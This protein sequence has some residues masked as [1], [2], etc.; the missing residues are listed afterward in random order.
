MKDQIRVLRV[1][2]YIGQRKWVE[3]TIARS[4]KGTKIVS[5]FGQIRAATIGD[6]P[7][8]LSEAKIMQDESMLGVYPEEINTPWMHPAP[9]SEWDPPSYEISAPIHAVTKTEDD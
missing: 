9:D 8:L 5:G 4:I 6:Y 3:E 1:V 7:E 2:E